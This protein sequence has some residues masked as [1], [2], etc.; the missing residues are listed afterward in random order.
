MRLSGTQPMDKMNLWRVI[1]KLWISPMTSI[2]L[3]DHIGL[4]ITRI[5]TFFQDFLEDEDLP[6]FVDL[7]NAIIYSIPYNFQ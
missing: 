6:L 2:M 3:L 4:I 7:P 1:G 5:Y